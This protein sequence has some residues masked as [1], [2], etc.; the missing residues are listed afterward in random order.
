MRFSFYALTLVGAALL[1]GQPVV[2]G[3]SASLESSIHSGIAI[4]ST[5]PNNSIDSI[6]TQLTQL[7]QLTQLIKLPQ[8]AQLTQL[9]KLAQL[10]QLIQRIRVFQL[11]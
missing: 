1:S 4:S 6:S 8:L 2:A 11:R 5:T 3:H 7:A 9:S 10:I